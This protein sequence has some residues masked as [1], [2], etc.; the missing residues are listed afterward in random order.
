MSDLK[1]ELLISKKQ[2]LNLIFLSQLEYYKQ[3]FS[4]L[5]QFWL[6][7]VTRIVEF[8]NFGKNDERLNFSP[9]KIHM[10]PILK[11]SLIVWLRYIA[12]KL[13]WRICESDIKERLLFQTTI[14]LKLKHKIT[15]FF[16]SAVLLEKRMSTSQ[17]TR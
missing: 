7:D 9:Q 15:C 12:L 2:S 14:F 5:T 10:I 8:P 11:L 16:W 17:N 1:N 6:Y 13:L 3:I 4:F